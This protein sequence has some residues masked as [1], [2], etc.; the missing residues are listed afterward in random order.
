MLVVLRVVYEIVEF[1]DEFGV[2]GVGFIGVLTEPIDHLF[3]LGFFHR[4][5]ITQDL[6][7]GVCHMGGIHFEIVGEIADNTGWVGVG[8]QE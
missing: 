8:F 7:D 4:N 6:I 2:S 1:I 5:E 3:G